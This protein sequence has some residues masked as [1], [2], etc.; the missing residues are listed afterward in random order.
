[1]SAWAELVSNVAFG[2]SAS[3]NPSPYFWNNYDNYEELNPNFEYVRANVIAY[4]PMI[5][6]NLEVTGLLVIRDGVIMNK[7]S[8]KVY[9]PCPPFCSRSASGG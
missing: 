2:G 4:H 6:T 8:D 7:P 1:M 3:N 9:L 5:E